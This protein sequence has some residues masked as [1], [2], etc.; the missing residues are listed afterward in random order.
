MD[1]PQVLTVI[2]AAQRFRTKPSDIL[3]IDDGYAAYCFDEAC[4]FI[5]SQLEDGKR[6]FFTRRQQEGHSQHS[7][8]AR[9]IDI[10]KKLGAEVKGID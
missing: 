2:Y 9:T 6:P 8:N 4:C 10:L 5:I 1:S 7:G 3:R